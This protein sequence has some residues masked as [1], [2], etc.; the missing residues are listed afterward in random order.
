MASNSHGSDGGENPNHAPGPGSS[1]IAASSVSVA[2]QTIANAGLRWRRARHRLP[3]LRYDTI[4]V[5]LPMTN[6]VNASADCCAA[7][8]SALPA[9]R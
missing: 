3:P 1:M 2:A 7:T 8:R 5:R 6:A 9:A 4:R